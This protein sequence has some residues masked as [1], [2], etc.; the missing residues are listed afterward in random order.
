M[1]WYCFRDREQILDLFE[2]SSGQRMHTRYFQ[3]GGVFEDIPA[4]FGSEGRAVHAT[5]C[6]TRVDQFAALL[7]KNEIV[8]QRLRGVAAVDEET[9]LGLGVTGP[10]LRAT[11]NPWDLRKAA[12]YS[13]YDHF[14]FKIPVG[15]VGDNYDR[16]R[17]RMAEMQ[18]VGA[19]SSSRRSTACPRAPY[20]T[21]EPQVRAAAAA[22]AG[23]LDGGADP[24]LQARHRGLPRAAGRGLLPDR[25]PARRARLLRALRRLLQARARAH[26]RPLVREPAGAQADGRRTSTSP[27]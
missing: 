9:L 11:G 15:T 18:R 1:F 21:D 23:D 25:V 2:M 20:I 10:L 4:G 13:S 27:T 5:R 14:D 17:V 3:V 12:P 19:G 7:D 26:A 8:L 24:P 16:Y 6:P 22:R